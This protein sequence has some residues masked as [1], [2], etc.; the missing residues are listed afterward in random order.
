MNGYL[1]QVHGPEALTAR[2]AAASGMTRDLLS[3]VWQRIGHRW[4]TVLRR[5]PSA[6]PSTALSSDTDDGDEALEFER[7]LLALRLTFVAVAL[8]PLVAFGLRAAPYA[9]LI[10]LAAL[11]STGLIATLVRQWPRALLRHQVALRVLDCALVWLV[12]ANYH[13]FLGNAYYDA[14]YALFVVAAAATHGRRGALLVAG[15]ASGFVLLGR[16][17]LVGND[18]LLPEIRHFTDAGFYLVFFAT[19]GLAVAFLMRRSREIAARREQ[20]WRAVLQQMPAGVAIAQAPSGRLIL[21]NEQLEQLL[22]QAMQP[23]GDVQGY[24]TQGL[25]HPGGQPYAPDDVPLARAIRTGEVVAGE[26]LEALRPD[27]SRA[28]LQVSAAPIRD[29]DGRIVAGVVTCHDV[30]WRKRTEAAQRFLDDAGKQ[31]AGT[32]EYEATLTSIARLAVPALAD[33]CLVDLL[34]GDGTIRRATVAHRDPSQQALAHLLR[35]HGAPDPAAPLGVP[36]ALRTGE[37]ELTPRVAPERLA[38]FARDAEHLRLLKQLRSR[39]SMNVPLVAR[40]RILGAITCIASDSGR[41]YGADDLA[42]AEDFARRAAVAVDNAR[43]YQEAYAAIQ[44]RDEFLSSAS[45]DLKNPLVSVK[46]YAQILGVLVAQDS[47][48]TNKQVAAGLAKIDRAATKMAGLIDELLDVAHL[49]AGRPLELRRRPTDLVALAHQAV[50]DFQPAALRHVLRV[51]PHTTSLVGLW[52]AGRLDR[53]FAN[54]LSN[55]VKYSP[56]GGAITVRLT[57]EAEAAAGWAVLVVQDEGMGIPAADLPHVFER[58]HRGGN[59][60]GQ[61]RGAG[62]GLA[63]VAQIVEQHGGTIVVDSQ[64]GHGATFTVRLPLLSRGQRDAPAGGPPAPAACA[65]VA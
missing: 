21:G 27:G 17:W 52:D 31:L 34:E 16:L 4:P 62:I 9:A 32:L 11:A 2:E 13:R 61:I 56:A 7:L 36:R 65:S 50:A 55:A 20:V 28:T 41:R 39:S 43:L 44:V 23:T 12:L 22:G 5:R 54:L 47:T 8:L 38:A 19:T 24:A 59:V 15:V 3:S 33:V 35:E 40:G 42:L 53:L 1:S 25:M 45:H 63:G 18:A 46:G 58:F 10:A 14:V 60:A 49:Q 37:S 30:T 64:E 6:G 29:A 48:P 51:E 57:R 26:E